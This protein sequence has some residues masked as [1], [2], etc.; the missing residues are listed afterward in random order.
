MKK[1]YGSCFSKQKKDSGEG[2]RRNGSKMILT[3][4]MCGSMMDLH[5]WEILFPVISLLQGHL[6]SSAGNSVLFDKWCLLYM[7]MDGELMGKE[8]E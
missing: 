6:A 5:S 4:S 8:Y 3:L 1:M 2:F 7:F